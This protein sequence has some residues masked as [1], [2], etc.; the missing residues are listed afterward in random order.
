M[1]KQVD[2]ELALGAKTDVRGTPSFFV[3]GKIA[4]NRTVEGFKAQVDAE[5]KAR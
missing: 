5:L 2:E 1:K 3:N 4:Q